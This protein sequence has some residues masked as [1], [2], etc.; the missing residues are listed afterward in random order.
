MCFI[1][2]QFSFLCCLSLAT[3]QLLWTLSRQSE[4]FQ[5][6]AATELAHTFPVDILM[7]ERLS[8]AGGSKKN[9]CEKM[10]YIEILLVDSE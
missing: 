7:R 8:E 6:C 9:F 5:K 1:Y 2:I 10:I 3:K 4:L